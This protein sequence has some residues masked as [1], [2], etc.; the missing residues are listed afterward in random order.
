MTTEN[1]IVKYIEYNGKWL[2]K[3]YDEK[4]SVVHRSPEFNSESEARADYEENWG[5]LHTQGFVDQG[6][7][8]RENETPTTVISPDTAPVAPQEETSAGTTAPEGEV[9]PGTAAPEQE[10]TNA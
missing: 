3:R 8:P 10:N 5:S 1:H 7:D 4:G 9:N 2:W 6:K